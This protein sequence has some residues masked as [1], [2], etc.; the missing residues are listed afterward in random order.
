MHCTGMKRIC[1]YTNEVHGNKKGNKEHGCTAVGSGSGGIDRRFRIFIQSA[2]K[3]RL[4]NRWERC[5]IIDNI[6]QLL[7]RS[8]HYAAKCKIHP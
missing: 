2:M 7:T 5:R 4:Q 8:I 1:V 6:G 3:S